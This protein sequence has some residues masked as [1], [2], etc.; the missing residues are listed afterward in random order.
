MTWKCLVH[1]G[2]WTYSCASALATSTFWFHKLHPNILYSGERQLSMCQTLRLSKL[3]MKLPLQQTF[4]PDCFCLC[5]DMVQLN[6]YSSSNL[7][8]VCWFPVWHIQETEEKHHEKSD[9]DSQEDTSCSHAMEG[10][11]DRT[12]NDHDDGAAQHKQLH[13]GSGTCTH[14]PIMLQASSLALWRCLTSSFSQAIT[15]IWSAIVFPR[16]SPTASYIAH[17]TQQSTMKFGKHRVIKMKSVDRTIPA[18]HPAELAISMPLCRSLKVCCWD[19]NAFGK[20]LRQYLWLLLESPESHNNLCWTT[21]YMSN[22]ITKH[23][24]EEL[25]DVSGC[26]RMTSHISFF[27]LI[28]SHAETTW[29]PAAEWHPALLAEK[30][31]HNI[32]PRTRMNPRCKWALG[33][34]RQFFWQQLLLQRVPTQSI[35]II[36]PYRGEVKLPASNIRWAN[37]VMQTANGRESSTL[38][39]FEFGFRF[40]FQLSLWM[41]HVHPKRCKCQHKAQEDQP[42][43][44]LHGFF[45]KTHFLSLNLNSIYL[46]YIFLHYPTQNNTNCQK[47]P[48]ADWTMNLS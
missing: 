8:S 48:E 44:I 9:S 13:L 31:W 41:I 38:C 5:P 26:K 6:A 24:L 43:Q 1:V 42:T 46:F 28:D 27:S 39:L 33:C 17:A 47:L 14:A 22:S 15:H 21:T 36:F 2:W 18:R 16:N 20:R 40:H 12:R 7:R 45:C 19:S 25:Q 34:P 3:P 37:V 29:A 35:N 30:P 23:T 11:E 10:G 4:S 32:S